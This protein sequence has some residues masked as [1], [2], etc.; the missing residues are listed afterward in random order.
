MLYSG[1]LGIEMSLLYDFFRI[2][3]RVF[4]CNRVVL[5]CMDM[6]FW[7]FTAYRTFYVMHT[8]SNGT[9]RWF[10]ILG[11][12]V[13]IVIYMEFIS[14]Y[15][16]AMGT[17]TLSAIRNVLAKVKKCLT[18]I[19]KMTIMKSVRKS[20]KKGDK[21]GKTGSLPDQIS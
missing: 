14:K 10:A 7:G 8:Y 19:L 3:R 21:D 11:T 12:A 16:V 17:S 9:L 18:N 6:F 1:A 5:G 13:V 4:L 2:I 20:K 15:V